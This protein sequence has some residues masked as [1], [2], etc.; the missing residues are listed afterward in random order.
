MNSGSY[1]IYCKSSRSTQTHLAYPEKQPA[2][3]AEGRSNATNQQADYA[4]GVQ[5]LY[6]PVS[7]ETL[8]KV[9]ESGARPLKALSI[10]AKRFAQNRPCSINFIVR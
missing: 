10:I 8:T 2:I 7:R 1:I 5:Q 9:K 6:N 3:L 4:T